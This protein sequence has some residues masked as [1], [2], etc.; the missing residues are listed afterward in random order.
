MRCGGGGGGGGDLPETTLRHRY[1]LYGEWLGNVVHDN[2]DGTFEVEMFHP[3]APDD[4]HP[5]T[6][7]A[8]Q[9]EQAWD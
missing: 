7:T 5:D 8:A 4:V 6:F 2:D 9:V 1:P 3:D